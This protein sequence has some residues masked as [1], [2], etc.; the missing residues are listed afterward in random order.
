M[1]ARIPVLVAVWA[2]L[3]P[4][5][6]PGPG[7]QSD[8]RRLPP[9]P[10]SGRVQRPPANPGLLARTRPGLGRNVFGLATFA[11]CRATTKRSLVFPQ[12][13]VCRGPF[14]APLAAEGA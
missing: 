7:V 3:Q 8:A 6:R 10:Q 1:A 5:P 9:W 14:L 11:G 12:G 4:G 13:A 2:P